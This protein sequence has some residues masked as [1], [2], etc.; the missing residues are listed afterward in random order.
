MRLVERMV[1]D[2]GAAHKHIKQVQQLASVVRCN[3]LVQLACQLPGM[4]Q[5]AVWVMIGACVMH[6]PSAL[7]HALILNMWL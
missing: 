6:G 7:H 4:Q 2:C 3:D 1:C 5:C